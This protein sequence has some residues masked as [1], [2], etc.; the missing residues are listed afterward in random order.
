MTYQLV[1]QLPFASIEDYDELVGLED[2]IV[3]AL[4]TLGDVDGHDAGTGE[5]NVFVLTDHPAAAFARI[6]TLA[7]PLGLKAAYREVGTEQF[8]VLHPPGLTEFAVA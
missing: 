6:E 7:L 5:M 4:G 1:V 8:T 2:R 3:D